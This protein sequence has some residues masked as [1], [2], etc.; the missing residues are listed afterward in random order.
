[1][2]I[3]PDLCVPICKAY[4][5][6]ARRAERLNTNAIL[7]NVRLTFFFLLFDEAW[8]AVLISGKNLPGTGESFHAFPCK[9]SWEL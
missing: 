9:T 7:S 1:M 5:T 6:K 8:K 3:L 2:L 4:S